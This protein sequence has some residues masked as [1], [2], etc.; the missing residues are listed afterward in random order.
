MGTRLLRRGLAAAGVLAAGVLT[1]CHSPN[2]FLHTGVARGDSAGSGLS[3]S[4]VV[5]PP[6]ERTLAAT[7]GAGG[8]MVASA[9]P[10][11]PVTTMP[12]T[13]VADFAPITNGG[14]VVF[15]SGSA[16]PTAPA[17]MPPA[18]PVTVQVGATLPPPT[19]PVQPGAIPPMPVQAITVQATGVTPATQQAAIPGTPVTTTMAMPAAPVHGTGTPILMLIQGP[20]GPQ[21]VITEV[22]S[23]VPLPSPTATPAPIPAPMPIPASA[24]AAPMTASAPVRPTPVMPAAAAM[25]EPGPAPVVTPV[26][27]PPAEPGS[28]VK[29]APDPMPTLTAPPPAAIPTPTPSTSPIGMKS[30]DSL[31]KTVSLKPSGGP[32]LPPMGTDG[33]AVTQAPGPKLPPT[34]GPMEDDIPS[35]PVFLPVAK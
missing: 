16:T 14:D 12:G 26:A 5:R 30:P 18:P 31:P 33:S 19:M 3:T 17:P 11:Q 23:V 35:A 21:Y 15:Q 6:V 20:N 10:V 9:D 27:L 8:M 25:P 28:P 29:P 4:M 22:L 24:P 7:P 13:P 2:Q 34:T 1:G 32:E